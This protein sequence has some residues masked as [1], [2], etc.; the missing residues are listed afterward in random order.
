[1]ENDLIKYKLDITDRDLTISSLSKELALLRS[2]VSSE[3][4]ECF[5]HLYH[6]ALPCLVHSGPIAFLLKE[7]LQMEREEWC[8]WTLREIAT[9]IT[10]RDKVIM[11]QSN[12]IKEV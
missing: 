2:N 7:Q 9:Q 4:S 3:K 11:H 10:E 6:T 5:L 12:T 8:A 1:M